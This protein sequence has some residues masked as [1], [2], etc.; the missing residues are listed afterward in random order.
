MGSFLQ[1]TGQGWKVYLLDGA[2]V[3]LLAALVFLPF[4][5]GHSRTWASLA[6]A[7]LYLPLFAWVATT[8]RCPQCKS[9]LFWKSLRERPF[10]DPALWLHRLEDCP[11]CGTDWER[12][13]RQDHVGAAGGR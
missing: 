1:K 4:P 12:P 10:P 7:C 5:P 11:V 3:A 8:V 2:A 13:K 9:Q 6:A